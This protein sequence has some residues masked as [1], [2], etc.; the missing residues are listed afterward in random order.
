MDHNSYLLAISEGWNTDGVNWELCLFDFKT[1]SQVWTGG[2]AVFNPSS[3]MERGRHNCSCR[4]H[5]CPPD[6]ASDS[7][8]TSKKPV[9][10]LEECE[11]CTCQEGQ[12]VH[13]TTSCA[14]YKPALYGR[15][16]T[17]LNHKKSFVLFDSSHAGLKWTCGRSC[18][19]QTKTGLFGLNTKH[20][21][22][23]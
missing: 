3:E 1:R 17:M 15:V 9:E 10:T 5:D 13:S 8:M 4:R 21:V 16:V 7:S 6:L 18:S 14:H 20:F 2:G 11:R 12:S 22:W 23:L 19:A